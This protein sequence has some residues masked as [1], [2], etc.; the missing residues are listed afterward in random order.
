MEV[1]YRR[2]G[3]PKEKTIRLLWAVLG[4]FK[5]HNTYLRLLPLQ[6]MWL[7]WKQ[8]QWVT[9]T[10][11]VIHIFIQRVIRSHGFDI[12]GRIPHTFYVFCIHYLAGHN[13]CQIN[14]FCLCLNVCMALYSKSLVL[15]TSHISPLSSTFLSPLV[16]FMSPLGMWNASQIQHTP[17]GPRLSQ[18]SLSWDC[19]HHLPSYVHFIKWIYYS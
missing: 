9:D 2:A 8:K 15:I 13:T 18:H 14:A 16:Y 3:T 6:W 5:M 4:W 17:D 11:V 19:L 12:I 7:E 10:T 1:N